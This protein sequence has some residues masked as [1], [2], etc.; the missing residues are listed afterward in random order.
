M[1]D[2]NPHIVGSATCDPQGQGG[3]GST[4][5][6]TSWPGALYLYHPQGQEHR[7]NSS[8]EM[9]HETPLTEQKYGLDGTQD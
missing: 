2:L 5:E 4:N 7:K 6:K 1:C 9:L 8:P 3:G